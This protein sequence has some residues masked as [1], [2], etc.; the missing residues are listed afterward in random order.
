VN[1]HLSRARFLG[2]LVL[3]ACRGPKVHEAPDGAA[4]SSSGIP[5]PM[6]HPPWDAAPRAPAAPEGMLWIPPGALVAGTPQGIL[7]RIADEE[8]SGEQVVMK[9]FFISVYPYPNEEGA[10]PIANV[11]QAEAANLCEQRKQRLCTELEWERAC[12]GPENHLFEYGDHYRSDVCATGS[13][14]RMIP[15]GLR[16]ACRSDFGVRDMHGSI[17]EW[18][19][20]SWARGRPEGLFAVRG[21]NAPAG[22]LAGRCANGVSRSSTYKSAT[23]GFRCCAGPENE[24]KVELHVERKPFLEV[25]ELDAAT[26]KRMEATIPEEGLAELRKDESFKIVRGWLWH[27]IGNEELIVGGGCTGGKLQQG[28][29]VIVARKVMGDPVTLAWAGSGRYVPSLDLE[30]DPRY[31][32]AY[33]GDERGHY[34]KL[35]TYAWGKVT[36]GATEH[37]VKRKAK[38]KAQADKGKARGKGH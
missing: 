4:P 24:A 35:L 31:L 22:E 16:V 15:S 20:S 2:A 10:I 37:N 12:K 6:A 1:P 30:Y 36:L 8:M 7:P 34:R 32:W 23:L 18:T 21:G 19:A 3:V 28:C 38:P 25:R 26:R 17:S 33:G 9:G 14:P 11:T 29:G 13:E 5:A 27:P